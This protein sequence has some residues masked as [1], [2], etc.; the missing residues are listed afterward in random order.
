MAATNT[1]I[2]TYEVVNSTFTITSAMSLR[3]VS[4]L[5]KSGSGV[6]SGDLKVGVLNSIPL[7]L[8]TD[9]PITFTA[10]DTGVLEGIT[11]DTTSIGVVQLVGKNI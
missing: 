2:F 1:Q 10:S 4:F 11:V 6:V 5:L 9:T 8:D 7:T 3:A